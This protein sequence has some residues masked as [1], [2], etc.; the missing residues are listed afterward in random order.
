MLL[1][2]KQS[3]QIE[4]LIEQKALLTN[5]VN[6]LT[7]ALAKTKTVSSSKGGGGGGGGG[8]NGGGNSGA[9]SGSKPKCAICGWRH[10]TKDCWE[11]TSNA[12]KRPDGWK[13]RLE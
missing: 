1:L 6:T 3:T 7:E 2:K 5:Q 8:G 9:S 4:K 11:L 12:A 10:N 13:S